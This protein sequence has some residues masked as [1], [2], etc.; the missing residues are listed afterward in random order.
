[1]E[2]THTDING[3]TSFYEGNRGI[4][5]TFAVGQL[6][7]KNN[8]TQT[9]FASTDTY[10]KIAG[11]T[12]TTGATNSKFIP[13]DNRLTCT[14]G[15]ERDYLAQ[16][17]ATVVPT[18][19]TTLK[20][21]VYDSSVVGGILEASEYEFEATAGDP[22]TVHITDL[23]KHSNGEYVEVHIANLLDT[24]PVTVTH[25]NVLTTQIG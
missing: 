23:H 16:V 10:V 13:T 18:T 14:A 2:S 9:S 21:A 6:Y 20:I 1:M 17:S 19:N 22:K 25:L 8:S 7:M 24:D 11:V 4:N 5:N 3:P 12:T 15:I